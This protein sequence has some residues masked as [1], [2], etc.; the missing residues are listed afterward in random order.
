MLFTGF[1][2]VAGTM[3]KPVQVRSREYGGQVRFRVGMRQVSEVGRSGRNVVGK[4]R[5]IGCVARMSEGCLRFD[6]LTQRRGAKY[7]DCCASKNY[8]CEESAPSNAR[9]KLWLHR[10]LAR[11][12]DS[13]FVRTSR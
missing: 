3:I 1:T 6:E 8:S 2:V 11:R 7:C 5:S 9:P 13:G 4:V 10:G 12:F